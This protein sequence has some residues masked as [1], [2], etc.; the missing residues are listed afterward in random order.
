MGLLFSG[1]VVF[2]CVFDLKFHD[3]MLVFLCIHTPQQL[4]CGFFGC[5]HVFQPHVIFSLVFCS[6]T[7]IVRC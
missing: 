4:S 5:R 6:K 2:V 1:S 7:S 3:M